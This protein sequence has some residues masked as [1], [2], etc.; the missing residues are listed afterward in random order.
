MT[1]NIKVLVMNCMCEEGNDHDFCVFIILS[2]NLLLWKTQH[3]KRDQDILP[4]DFT[5][6]AYPYLRKRKSC[7]WC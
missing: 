4:Q 7:P 2:K 1:D 5:L 6:M 3:F